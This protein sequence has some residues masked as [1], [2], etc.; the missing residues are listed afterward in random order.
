MHA[1]HPGSIDD[2]IVIGDI[3]ARDVT[4]NRIGKEFG[5]LG[6]VAQMAAQLGFRP[7]GD[8]RSIEPHRA[9]RGLGDPDEQASQRGFSRAG[10]TDDTERLARR[11]LKRHTAQ[12]RSCAG[13]GCMHDLLDGKAACRAR[14]AQP[15]LFDTHFRQ[16]PHQPGIGIACADDT[17]PVSDHLL[18][19]LQCAPEKRG[20]ADCEDVT[21][22]GTAG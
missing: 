20:I 9:G 4:G 7:Q 1:R 8:V 18:H 6:H 10:R 19:G 14:Q 16:Q 3:E 2:L 15:L 22:R 5:F 12:H 17:A 21:G 13:N 11:N